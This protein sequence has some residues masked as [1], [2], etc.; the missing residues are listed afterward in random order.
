MERQTS[1]KGVSNKAESNKGQ[2][3][4]DCDSLFRCLACRLKFEVVSGGIFS[5]QY[6]TRKE[7]GSLK[8]RSETQ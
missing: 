5:M 8:A 4:T 6:L 2:I 1:N 7:P 3:N